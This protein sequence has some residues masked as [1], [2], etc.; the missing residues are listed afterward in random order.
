MSYVMACLKLAQSTK[1]CDS[2]ST[3]Y[4][5]FNRGFFSVYFWMDWAVQQNAALLNSIWKNRIKPNGEQA[6][7]TC[8]APCKLEMQGPL[9]TKITEKFRINSN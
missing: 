8:R 9:I 3:V 7:E 5:P 4:N 6:G 1:K 2:L